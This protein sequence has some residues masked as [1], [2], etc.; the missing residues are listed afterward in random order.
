M[1]RGSGELQCDV[2]DAAADAD[3]DDNDNGARCKL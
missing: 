3:G 2:D 1:A